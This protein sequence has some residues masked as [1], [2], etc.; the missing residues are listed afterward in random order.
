MTISSCESLSTGDPFYMFRHLD[1][2]LH[3]LQERESAM[4]NWEVS[5]ESYHYAL[6]ESAKKGNIPVVKAIIKI[7]SLMLAPGEKL[8]EYGDGLGF[9]PL[10]W[11][12]AKDKFVAVKF[13]LQN[14]VD[15]NTASPRGTT[16]ISIAAARNKVPL[17][18][19]LLK[20]GAF[21]DEKLNQ[22]NVV[23]KAREALE[24]EIEIEAASLLKIV[25]IIPFEVLKIIG[26]YYAD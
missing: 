15:A 16:A 1:T 25:P 23:V 10:L 3:F 6:C 8:L 18:I 11:A 7:A 20:Y 19:V 2:P 26:G 17:V 12:V 22:R 13:L 9:T 4:K 24:H 5:L 21:V 14:D